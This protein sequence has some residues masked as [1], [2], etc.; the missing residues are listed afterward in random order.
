MITKLMNKWMATICKYNYQSFALC[1]PNASLHH[2]LLDNCK[3]LMMQSSLWQ[4]VHTRTF[5]ELTLDILRDL[6]DVGMAKLHV[7]MAHLHHR[8]Q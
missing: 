3:Y 6:P 7:A 2:I 8:T 4:M 1:L 5:E